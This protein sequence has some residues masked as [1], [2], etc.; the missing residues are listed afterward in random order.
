MKKNDARVIN[1]APHFSKVSPAEME[2]MYTFL[3]SGMIRVVLE[4][5]GKYDK[6]DVVRFVN[7]ML[8][9]VLEE[10]V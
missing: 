9:Q 5:Y 8:R 2:M 4:S 1:T 6:E 3:T 7:K 10:Y